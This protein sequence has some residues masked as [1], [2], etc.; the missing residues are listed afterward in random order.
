M[1]GRAL[2]LGILFILIT[3]ALVA[4]LVQLQLVR[5]RHYERAVAESLMMVDRIPAKRGRI[6]DRDGVP[7]ADNRAEY[8]LAVVLAELE[9][10]RSR[11]I[12]VPLHRL[13]GAALDR[14]VAD[15]S[16]RSSLSA[17]EL[18]ATL[19]SELDRYPGV[20]RRRGDAV[21]G[22]E[23]ELDLVARADIA[24][25]TN[26][27]ASDPDALGQDR[28]G[29]LAQSGLLGADPAE[30]IRRE[31]AARRRQEVMLFSPEEWGGF[32]AAL[33]RRFQAPA[34][35]IGEA[36]GPFAPRIH[37]ALPPSDSAA[38]AESPSEVASTRLTWRLL[39]EEDRRRAEDQLVRFL[40]EDPRSVHQA[41]RAAWLRAR[42][43]A[44]ET[45][46]LFAPAATRERLAALLPEEMVPRRVA[47]AGVPPARDRIHLIQGDEPGR[48]DGLFARL[49]R[50]LSSTL[51]LRASEVEGVLLARTTPL[52]PLLSRRRHRIHHIVFDPVRLDALV[53]ELTAQL[54]AAG[55][56]ISAIELEERLAGVRRRADRDWRGQTRE[57][58]LPLVR[59]VPRSLAVVLA[60]S[61]LGQPDELIRAG[62]FEEAVPRCPGLRV[63]TRLGREYPY[64]H[65]T[66]HLAGWVGQLSGEPGFSREMAR[67]SGLDPGGW[68]GR[69]GLERE[70]DR[71]LQGIFGTRK[72]MITPDGLEL[73]AR[74]REPQPGA[75]LHTT[76]DLEL[77]HTA[78][79]ALANWW[80]LANELYDDPDQGM[81]FNSPHLR[82]EARVAAAAAAEK[83][84]AGCVL[85]DV[86]DGAI[87]AMAST[88]TFDL[89]RVG[90][91][92]SELLDPELH[93]G[94]PLHDYAAEAWEAPGSTVKPFVGLV[95]ML[96][97]VYS[98]G[99]VL[100]SDGYMTIYQG[101]RIMRDHAPH[102]SGGRWEM[103]EAIAKSINT[104]FATLGEE[105]GAAR[106]AWWYERIGMGRANALDVGWQV[107]ASMPS[108][109][110]Q[111]P[112][113]P[114]DTWFI[115]IGQKMAASPLQLVAI[116]ALIANGGTVIRPHCW[117]DIQLGEPDRIDIPPDYL[118]EIRAGMEGVTAP[119]GTAERLVLEGPAT[120]IT[121][122]A[123]TG[124]SQWGTTESRV[125]G[126]TPN[127]AWLVGYAPADQPEVAFAIFIRCGYSG[128]RACSGVA[129]RLLETYFARKALRQ[130]M[131][132]TE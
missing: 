34:R 70:Y 35:L 37:V 117:R 50:R 113:Y 45:P 6:L 105:I 41:L 1:S 78:Q 125:A 106:L 104:F 66:C 64:P 84:I 77:Q 51:A 119:G 120:G 97:G 103:R 69:R 102:D 39:T 33:A 126:R 11:A 115:S 65:V 130:K 132:F 61:G 18:R 93:P 94:R 118:A 60:G 19:L 53:T 75:D 5:G 43:L 129:K 88:P 52:G 12:T 76:I 7:F 123:K 95:A 99:E 83:G 32:I 21:G 81:G 96:E 25:A 47:I 116:P 13:D 23:M 72:R 38:P 59:D 89:A 24:R 10:P 4:R 48:R 44:V 42:S 122:A 71:Y 80:E 128:G 15:L 82:E 100:S 9:L 79:D 40:A 92:Y 90:E 68:S 8:H 31:F 49:L 107:S 111:R 85:V 55:V 46:W 74:P 26:Q 54:G 87:R 127:H 131:A 28:L 3:G 108:P 22:E 91:I 121:V 20:A 73:A 57:D 17:D 58:P 98:P 36:L 29:R 110:R 124:T 2:W 63:V 114:S 86:T 14:I 56:A 101:R 109:A 27:S 16:L 62:D 30:A 67:I 112:W